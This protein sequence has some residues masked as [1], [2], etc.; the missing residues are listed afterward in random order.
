MMV[1]T[2]GR[3]ALR[4]MVSLA[5]RK[6]E[7]R[8]SLAEISKQQGISLKYMETII[9]VLVKAG[10]VS[11]SR[12]KG[13]GY[14]LTRAPEEYTVGSI[15][16]LTEGSLAPV[17]CL[18]CEGGN[19]C[20]RADQCPTLPMWVKLDRIIHD[21]LQSVTLADLVRQADTLQNSTTII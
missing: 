12:G 7:G 18:D 14:V 5:Q 20:Q 15:L 17:A 8:I 21:Y 6:D 13:G 1:S 4:I 3:Y 19:D 16:E 11:G 9:S 2:K 10:H